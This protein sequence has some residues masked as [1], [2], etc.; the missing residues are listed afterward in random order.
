ME[1]LKTELKTKII[2]VLNL[3]DI[4]IND[5]QDT[6]PLFGD[7]LGLDSIDALELIVLMDKDYGIKLSD[8]KEGRA[9][10]QSIET[11]A[12]YISANRTK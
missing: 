12:A 9:I 7:G 10:F 6:D 8:P 4:E 1:N 2:D 11:M 5:I 3:E